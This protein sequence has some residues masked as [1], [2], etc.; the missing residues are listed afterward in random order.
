MDVYR[1]GVLD[2]AIGTSF[3]QFGRV[4]EVSCS[5]S[6]ADIFQIKGIADHLYLDPFHQRNDLVPDIT[7]LLHAP[8]LYEVLKAPLRAVVGL[9]PGIIY[10]HQCKMV[11]HLSSIEVGL[12]IV[13]MDPLVLRPVKDCVPY[14][15]HTADG[16]N[17]LGALVLLACKQHFAEH[18]IQREFCH[19]AS[20]FGQLPTIIKCTK[21]VKLLQC[22]EQ[23][24]RWRWIHEVKVDQVVDT[25]TLQH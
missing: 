8:K 16:G 20:K 5:D 24:L 14:A 23:G 12:C 25:Q 4:V 7:C 1:L 6:L 17:L 3:L 22:P 19:S 9:Y 10:V 21:G 13:C 2:G 11:P 18:W 15:Q